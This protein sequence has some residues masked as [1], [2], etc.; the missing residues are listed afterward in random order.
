MKPFSFNGFGLSTDPY[1]VTDTDAFTAP[2][3]E[4]TVAELARAHGGVALFRRFKPRT[5]NISGYFK[6][7]DSDALEADLDALKN[8]LLNVTGQ[9]AVGYR[10][11]FR[12]WTAEGQNVNISRGATDVTKMAYSAQFLAPSPF[13]TDGTTQNLFTAVT[14]NTNRSFQLGV[15]N[16]GTFLALPFITI[17]MTAISPTNAPI[18]ITIGNPATNEYLSFSGTFN[19][20]DVITI[21]VV[22]EQIYQNATLLNP[23]GLF[24]TWLPGAGIMDYSDTAAS[25]TL[26]LTGTYPPRYL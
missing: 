6:D 13:A 5:I 9:L 7:A 23:T 10:S 11:G 12:Y 26:S 22:N 20:G 1:R 4:I 25:G 21:D 24:P 14:G 19:N 8:N 15:N 2:T 17:T 18:T 16:I 3:K